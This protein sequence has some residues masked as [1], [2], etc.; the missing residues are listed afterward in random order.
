MENLARFARAKS[1]FRKFTYSARAVLEKKKIMQRSGLQEAP[2]RRQFKDYYVIFLVSA[3]VN[4][5]AGPRY[6]K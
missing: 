6:T 3:L 4:L 5:S 2:P 1:A